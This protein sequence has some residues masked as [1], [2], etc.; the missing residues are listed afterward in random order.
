MAA[1]EKAARK[2]TIE[3][4]LALGECTAP[5]Y[6]HPILVKNWNWS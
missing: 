5:E 3:R 2:G 1:N 6:Q 4:A